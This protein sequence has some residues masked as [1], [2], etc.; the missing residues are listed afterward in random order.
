MNLRS[1]EELDLSY[2]GLR[3]LPEK[4]DSLTHLRKLWIDNNRLTSLPQSL[5]NLSDL[6]GLNISDNQIQALPACFH[7]LEKLKTLSMFYT[8]KKFVPLLQELL[9]KGI[10]VEHNCDEDDDIDFDKESEFEDY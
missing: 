6:E 4:I 2:C 1:L 7:K 10:T 9:D 8:L 5:C 3:N